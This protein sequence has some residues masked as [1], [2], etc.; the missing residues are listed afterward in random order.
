[1]VYS[2]YG[3]A[4]AI[5][6]GSLVQTGC[7]ADQGESQR[8]EELADT[9]RAGVGAFAGRLQQT[10]GEALASGGPV[11]AT[12]VCAIDAPIIAADAS[13]EHDMVLARTALRVRNPDNAPDAFERAILER[14][15]AAV[16]AGTPIA[17]LEHIEIVTAAD[18]A[19]VFR[20]M[21]AIPMLDQ[22]CSACHGPALSAEV[23]AAVRMSY[24]DDQATGFLP[25]ELRGAFSVSKRLP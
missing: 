20:F 18:G 12:A 14:F 21:K 24:P 7:A 25:G 4:M 15:S 11:A 16:S 3:V 23:T 2:R 22:P 5:L 9:A 19:R 8:L 6:M 17:T 13:R 1:M 10:L